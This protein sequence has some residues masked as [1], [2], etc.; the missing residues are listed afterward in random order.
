MCILTIKHGQMT[1]QFQKSV[2]QIER[3]WVDASASFVGE[4]EKSWIL[5]K[6]S[7]DEACSM[8]DLDLNLILELGVHFG[9]YDIIA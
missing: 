1:V 5:I 6:G 4:L 8:E 9:E 2:V 7:G 3:R